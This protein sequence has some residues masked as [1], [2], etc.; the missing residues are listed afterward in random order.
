MG[1]SLT[2]STELALLQLAIQLETDAAATDA[3]RRQVR[4]AHFGATTEKELEEAVLGVLRKW[5]G[6]TN[7]TTAG[8]AEPNRRAHRGHRAERAG[9]RDDEAAPRT[10]SAAAAAVKG[11]DDTTTDKKKD[12]REKKSKKD[13]RDK[14]DKKDKQARKQHRT[15]RGAT[16]AEAGEEAELAAPA[17]TNGAAEMTAENLEALMASDSDVDDAEAAA[18]P[19]TA[20]D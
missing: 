3:L 7:R 14:K 9:D 11:G 16:N 19:N 8:I 20:Q 2:S 1:F 10:K 18:A 6:K 13:K 17:E 15:E 4:R 12:K 5:E